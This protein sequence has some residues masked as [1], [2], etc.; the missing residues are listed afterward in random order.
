M[1]LLRW[2]LIL[3][4]VALLTLTFVIGRRKVDS[5]GLR[6][7]SLDADDTFDPSTEDLSVPI[8]GRPG[9]SANLS[10]SR[11]EGGSGSRSES[12]SESREDSFLSDEELDDVLPPKSEYASEITGTQVEL[13][14]GEGFDDQDLSDCLLYTSDAADE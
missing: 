14:I 8:A 7:D 10:A 12:R 3:S 13:G 11:A 5:G 6:R 9:S 4:G 2:V 1:E